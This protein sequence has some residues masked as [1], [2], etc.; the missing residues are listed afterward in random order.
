MVVPHDDLRTRA[1]EL[2]NEIASSAPLAVRSIRRTLRKGLAE[3]VRAATDRE[4][5]EQDWLQLTQDYR[6]GVRATAERREPD[7]QGR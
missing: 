1:F 4:Q 5:V 3:R 2:A 6:E 7:F